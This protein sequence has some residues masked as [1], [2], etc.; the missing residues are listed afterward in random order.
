M[1]WI[2]RSHRFRNLPETTVDDDPL[3]FIL[4]SLLWYA[5]TWISPMASIE[6][7]TKTPP[8]R[9]ET[10]SKDGTLLRT[11]RQDI[12][13]IL[14][15]SAHKELFRFSAAPVE[16]PVLQEEGIAGFM[17][18]LIEDTVRDNCGKFRAETD[19]KQA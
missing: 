8:R 15:L 6:L 13:I 1:Q 14:I 18:R 2:Q 11:E 3:R 12:E 16:I 17:L 7:L 5:L 4:R 19:G 10:I 9:I